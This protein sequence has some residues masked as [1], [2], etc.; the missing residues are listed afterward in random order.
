MKPFN[1]KEYNNNPSRKVITRDGR[2]VRIICTDAKDEYPLIAL[3][4]TNNNEGIET[5]K[6]DGKWS[7]RQENSD[8]DLFFA[9]EK[10]EGY[11]NLFKFCYGLETGPVYETKEEADKNSDYGKNPRFIKTIHIEWDD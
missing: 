6:L 10:K 7:N 3:I 11:V 5:Y 8:L 2:N 1:L 9:P 4:S